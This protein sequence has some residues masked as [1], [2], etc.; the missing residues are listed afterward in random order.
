MWIYGR[1]PV[2][3]AAREGGVRRVLVAR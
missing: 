1:N 3:E 2:L